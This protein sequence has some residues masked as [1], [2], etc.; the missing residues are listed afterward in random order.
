M[1]KAIASSIDERKDV[2][3]LV[4]GEGE[5]Q[6][7]LKSLAKELNVQEKV[8]FLGIRN[9]VERI[10]SITDVFVCP[11]IWHEAFGLVIAE[12]MASATP[13]VASRIGGIPE[14]VSDNVTGI[15]V[16]PSDY[17]ELAKAIGYLYNNRLKLKEMGEKA[18]QRATEHFN[19]ERTVEQYIKVY[20]DYL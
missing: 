10:L 16:E 4:A 6:D 12:A 20:E 19:L 5:E 3:A 8:R 15:L 14:I 9:D 11:S 18:K 2:M 1:I 17:K 13:V 7:R